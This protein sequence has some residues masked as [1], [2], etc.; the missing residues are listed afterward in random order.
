MTKRAS[1]PTPA[2][3]HDPLGDESI[4]ERFYRPDPPS[5]VALVD[6][7]LLPSA[8]AKKPRPTHYK[9]VCISLY[10]DD[11]ERLERLVDTLKSRGHTKA[12]KSQLIRAALDQVDLEKVPRSH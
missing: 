12:N 3:H 11:I 5:P 9:I 4:L 8:L 6:D 1:R 7:P 10:T 2:L